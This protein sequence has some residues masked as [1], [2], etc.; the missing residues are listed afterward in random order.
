[1]YREGGELSVGRN[2]ERLAIDQTHYK[3]RLILSAVVCGPGRFAIWREMYNE[4]AGIIIKNLEQIFFEH[5]SVHEILMD[6]ASGNGIV[7][8]H[9]RTTKSMVEKAIISPVEA[10]YWYN[11][12]TRSGQD[13]KSV[14]QI[15]VFSYLWR[16]PGDK[17]ERS[18]EDLISVSPVKSGE[19]VWVK[20]PYSIR[21]SQ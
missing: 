10:V 15:S 19:Q 4:T 20:P 18:E 5:D 21:T 17:R 16:Q 14:P 12:S 9:H 2:W 1:M 6:N 7:E 8:R 11:M 13:E 3:N